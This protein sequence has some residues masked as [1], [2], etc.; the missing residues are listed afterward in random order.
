MGG[1]VGGEEGLGRDKCVYIY[2]T[3]IHTDRRTFD[4]RLEGQ[5]VLQGGGHD[6]AVCVFLR[7]CVC[8]VG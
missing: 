4:G 3:H 6:A 1:L 2:M 5:E 7:V 8:V